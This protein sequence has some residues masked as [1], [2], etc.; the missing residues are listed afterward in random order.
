VS[1]ISLPNIS[2][3]SNGASDVSG[4]HCRH[5]QRCQ[6][7]RSHHE[8][9]RFSTDFHSHYIR[10][11]PPEYPP[12]QNTKSKVTDSAQHKPHLQSTPQ[13]AQSPRYSASPFRALCRTGK[14]QQAEGP[15]Q[16]RHARLTSNPISPVVLATGPTNHTWSIHGTI[17]P[18]AHTHAPSAAIPGGS[19]LAEFHA[20]RSY[21]AHTELGASSLLRVSESCR[22]NTTC[23]IITTATN[24]EDQ[25]PTI[26]RLPHQSA[27]RMYAHDQK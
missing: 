16:L 1:N 20:E 9:S 6:T 21:A 17:S 22:R 10:T 12:L 11:S 25:Y 2:N 5:P 18:N 26:P 19:R 3:L 15:M 7:P 23:S 8:A 14:G 24:V 4:P 13:S 27:A